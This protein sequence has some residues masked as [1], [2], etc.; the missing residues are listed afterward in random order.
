MGLIEVQGEFHSFK[1]LCEHHSSWYMLLVHDLELLDNEKKQ[2]SVVVL[3]QDAGGG[4]KFGI[5]RV[6]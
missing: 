5:R 4:S 6:H 3:A 2:R 1:A